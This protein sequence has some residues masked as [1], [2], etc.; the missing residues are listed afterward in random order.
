MLVDANLKLKSKEL[1]NP[2]TGKT[3]NKTASGFFIN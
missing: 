3:R 1:T 2:L